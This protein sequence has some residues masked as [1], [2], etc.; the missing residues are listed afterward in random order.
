MKQGGIILEADSGRYRAL[1]VFGQPVH[2]SH[3]QIQAALSQR[4]GAKYANFFA[5]PQWEEGGSQIRWVAPVPGKVV[6]WRDLDPSERTSKALDLQ[7]MRGEIHNY[8]ADLK[9]DASQSKGN[10][11]G[12]AFATV[13]E[14]SLRTPN[15]GHLHFVG[16]QPVMT[17]W[18]FTEQSGASFEPLSVV[19][20]EAAPATAAAAA[21][22][23]RQPIPEPVPVEKASGR[24]WWHWLLLLLGLLLLLLLAWLWWNRETGGL[25]PSPSEISVPPARE[26]VIEEEKQDRRSR[27]DEETRRRYL[28]DISRL[29]V[30]Q[31]GRVIGPD[32]QVI[33]GVTPED[34]GLLDA[35]GPAR[36][37]DPNQDGDGSDPGTPGLEEEAKP[38]P[39]LPDDSK[40][41][42]TP[43]EAENAAPP[44]AED[45]ADGPQ[46]QET[47][48]PTP[49]SDGAGEAPQDSLNIPDGP[50]DGS[51]ESAPGIGFMSGKWRSDAGL[52]DENGMPLDQT[53][54]F[55]DQGKGRS[56]VRRADGVTCSAPAEAKMEGGALQVRESENLK[57]S[58]GNV[59]ERSETICEKGADGKT[60]CRGSYGG[61]EGYDV[62]IKRANP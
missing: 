3:I 44:G 37:A 53:Y 46:G 47:P 1:G 52:T 21:A 12:A 41:E 9:A 10:G 16:D 26:S 7:I 55:D 50:A 38:D 51:A 22:A 45:S 24:P 31:D 48:P 17:F 13:L 18:G 49:P 20:K 36:L 30:D 19:P 61:G 39:S 60:Q 40:A 42:N 4:L 59:F 2:R 54:E 43:P 32:G 33:E 14:Q 62:K 11:G 5:R 27:L 28:S 56:V 57:C 6:D 25:G 35:E 58:D 29:R 23:E 15:D 8:L 34:L